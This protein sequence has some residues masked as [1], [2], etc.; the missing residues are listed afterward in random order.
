MTRVLACGGLTIDWLQT[1]EGR[2]GPFL[3]GNAAYSAV[4]AWL[5]G[6]DAEVVAVTGDDYPA[7]LL[8]ELSAAGIGTT[9]VRVDPGPS[10]RVL[11]DESG[12]RRTISY[13]PGSGRNDRLDPLPS[14]LPLPAPGDAMH[15]CAIPGRSQRALLAAARR[16]RQVVTLDTVLIPGEI[17]PHT[18]TLLELA[19]DASVFMPSRDELEHHWPGGIEAA[20]D[21]LTAAGCA[22]VIVK[23]GAEG[24]VGRDGHTSVRLPAVA[25]EVVDPI[26]AGDAYCGAACARLAMGESLPEAMS[27]GAAAASVVIEG[28]GAAR[29]LT[30][31]AR[32]T[33]AERARSLRAEPITA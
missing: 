13:L 30:P 16:R 11:L 6:A 18:E 12:P 8:E 26:G 4:G 24:S 1:A 33:V 2:I 3:G 19:R 20:L 27:W 10:F 25:T 14:Q 29:A 5:A 23:L 15:I 7:E 32:T 22:R 17:E 31:A 9:S 21:H 28:H